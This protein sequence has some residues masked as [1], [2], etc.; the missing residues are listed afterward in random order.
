MGMSIGRWWILSWSGGDE[1][2]EAIE[3][4]DL[5]TGLKVL[6]ELEELR[7]GTPYCAFNRAFLLKA[8]GDAEGAVES[9]TEASRRAPKLEHVWMQRG[10]L[11]EELEQTQDAIFCFRR[12]LALPPRHAEALEGLAR[13]GAMVKCTERERQTGKTTVE[14]YT[15]DEWMK[16]LKRNVAAMRQDDPNLRSLLGQ[17]AKPKDGEAALLLVNRILAGE[18]PDREALLIQKA[19]ALRR[20]KRFKQAKELLEKVLLAGNCDE[21]EAY[22]A[23]AWVEFDQGRVGWGWDLIDDVLARNVNH[24]KAIM[25]KLK[26]GAETPG[27][28]KAVAE[29]AEANGSWRGYWAASITASTEGDR[30]A[31]LKYAERAY[32]LAPEERDAVF[33]YANCLNN[34]DEGEYLAAL[35]HPRLPEAKGDYLLK[36]IFAGAMKKLGLPEEAVRILRE[37][38]EETEDFPIEWEDRVRHFLDEL[39]G[40]VAMGDVEVEVHPNTEVLRR[41]IWI[42]ADEGP[43][44]E[45]IP[46]GI[47]LPAA[48]AVRLEPKPGYTVSTASL[49]IYH[50][51]HHTERQATS[52]GWFRVH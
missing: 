48:K 35:V 27:G 42:G 23:L 5:E 50:H 19:D 7:P 28:A 6:E 36:Y 13:L 12:A 11:H 29:W 43:T 46:P 26:I 21:A 31:A 18:P 38:L 4:G 32:R 2:G 20:L 49:E 41:G 33:I 24:E 9:A 52:L 51:T 17:S 10:M 25:M 34:A 30:E 3:T 15:P 40:Y 39:T 45:I 1:I 14:Y 22:Y 16:L 37:V 44:M 8:M 47:G